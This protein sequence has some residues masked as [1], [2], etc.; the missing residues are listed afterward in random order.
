M[1]ASELFEAW[2]S[3]AVEVDVVGSRAHLGDPLSLFGLI[4]EL[5]A[6]LQKQFNGDARQPTQY[7][8]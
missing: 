2:Y 4:C 3:V 8:R 6:A 7:C 5:V 1:V